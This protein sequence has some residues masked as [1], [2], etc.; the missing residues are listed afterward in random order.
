MSLPQRLILFLIDGLRPDAVNQADTPSFHRLMAAGA[1]TLSA[2]TVFPELSLPCHA[3]LFFSLPPEQHGIF[4]NDWQPIPGSPPGLI[5]VIKASGRATAAV[6]SWEPL[7]DLSRPDSLD[8]SYYHRHTAPESDGRELELAAAAAD[9][10]VREEP[11]FT[12][13][14]IEVVDLIGHLSGW[15]SPEYL[16]AVTRADRALELLLDELEGAALLD[17][18]AILVTADHGGHE[19]RHGP[20]FAN[21]ASHPEDALIPWILSG[22]GVRRGLELQDPVNLMD[23]APTLLSLLGLEFPG[24]RSGQVVREALED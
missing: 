3:S 12:F 19:H 20:L 1:S 15:M 10:L 14:Y 18:T 21:E 8:F 9:F 11:A 2:Q 13:V 7:R 22:P 17:S 4:Y 6:Y 23:S 24:Q 16:D 5:D